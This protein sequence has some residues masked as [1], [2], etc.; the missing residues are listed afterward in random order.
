MSKDTNPAGAMAPNVIPVGSPKGI[1]P[2]EPVSEPKHPECPDSLNTTR[3]NTSGIKDNN[4][5]GAMFNPS[6]KNC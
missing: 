4:P 5:G 6:K 1:V 3:G 2:H